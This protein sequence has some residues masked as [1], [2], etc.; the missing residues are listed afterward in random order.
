MSSPPITNAGKQS[1]D[2][3]MAAPSL[4]VDHSPRASVAIDPHQGDDPSLGGNL[5][6]S[7]ETPFQQRT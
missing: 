2:T 7:G 1:F 6:V 5:W 4:H 3:N